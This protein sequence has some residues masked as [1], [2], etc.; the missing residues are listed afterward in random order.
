MDDFLVSIIIPVFNEEEIIEETVKTIRRILT[1]NDIRHEFVLIDDGSDDNTWEKIADLSEKNPLIGAIKLSRNFGKESAICAGLDKASGDACLIIDSDMQ[2]PPS[3]I[4]DMFRL[5][6]DEGFEVVEGVKSSRGNEGHVSKFS[7][8]LF[9]KTLKLLSG[10]DLE[11]TSDFKL[12][13]RKVVTA[14]KRMG[15][16]KTFFRGMSTWVGF[17]HTSILFDVQ[18]RKN[19]KSGWSFFKLL[20]L[21]VNAITAYSSVPL[22]IVTFIG[23]IF[24]TGSFILGT[25]TLYKKF[26]G[27]A[28]S[29]F[30]TVILLLLIIGSCLM[31]SLGII[32]TYIARIYDEVKSRPRYIISDEI[33]PNNME[34]GK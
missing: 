14:W 22:H 21:A 27:H 31:I 4:P 25:Q 16:R 7:A 1:A 5:W 18:E 26:A 34:G 23:I 10:Y 13:D 3:L 29:G 15:E 11:N 24:L 33:T 2:H 8:A 19:G 20:K 17:K 12:L 32:G 30:T 28:L 6:K 9:Y